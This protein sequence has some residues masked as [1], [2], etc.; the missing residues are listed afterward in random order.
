METTPLTLL[1][2][3]RL[4]SIPVLTSDPRMLRISA[5]RLWPGAVY[6]DLLNSCHPLRSK[7]ETVC[8]P[9]INDL[10]CPC[11]AKVCEYVDPSQP[12][13]SASFYYTASSLLP[14]QHITEQGRAGRRAKWERGGKQKKAGKEREMWR[15]Q[16]R[17]GER[18]RWGC[19][20]SAADRTEER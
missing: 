6:C 17:G 7:S 3:S 9:G 20:T 11:P 10:L 19:K 16:E 1:P 15:Q 4:P 18:K 5:Q 13:I 14:R 12:F 8:S 2:T